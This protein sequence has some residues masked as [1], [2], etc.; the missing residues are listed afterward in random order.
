MVMRMTGPSRKMAPALGFVAA[1]L[2]A[3][4]GCGPTQVAE[5]PA[6]EN[7]PTPLP[8]N[9]PLIDVP[10]PPPVLIGEHKGEDMWHLRSG[11]NVAVLLCHG[12]D[13]A[14][15]VTGYNQMLA[16]HNG[17]LSE[18]AKIEVELFRARGGRNWQDSY[19]DHMTKVYNSY[20]RTLDRDGFC[21][22]SK[23][24]LEKASAASPI[25]FS[26]NATVMLWELNKAA[27]LPDPDGKLARAAHANGQEPATSQPVQTVHATT[28]STSGR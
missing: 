15:M 10:P 14:A 18:A 12:P 8:Q 13:N 28:N 24:L 19:D 6:I 11:L 1:S 9:I 4:A 25:E 17:L 26:E 22:R 7:I 16:T 2:L 5:A 23:A 20:S 3:L 27:G 21:S